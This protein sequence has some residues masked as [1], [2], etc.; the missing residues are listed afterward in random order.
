MTHKLL[1]RQLTTLFLWQIYCCVV[2]ASRNTFARGKRAGCHEIQKRANT[3]THATSR[4]WR[5]TRWLA[6]RTQR[7]QAVL[8]SYKHLQRIQTYSIKF[9]SD[10]HAFKENNQHMKKTSSPVLTSEPKYTSAPGNKSACRQGRG[11]KRTE[12]VK[13]VW[14]T[15]S[16]LCKT[17]GKKKKTWQKC[18]QLHANRA[19]PPHQS[20]PRVHL[21]GWFT[22]RGSGSWKPPRFEQTTKWASNQ[23]VSENTFTPGAQ[24]SSLVEILMDIIGWCQ[25]TVQLGSTDAE[26]Q[27]DGESGLR[28]GSLWLWSGE[29][30]LITKEEDGKTEEESVWYHKR[31][32]RHRWHGYWTWKNPPDFIGEKSWILLYLCFPWGINDKKRLNFSS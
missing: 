32:H 8:S 13:N 31:W 26:R 11:N 1:M 4:T 22:A 3:W 2:E 17:W 16:N 20:G 25:A 12:A 21:W 15:S 10:A 18:L 7:T 9:P 28:T 19:P 30:E 6:R 5:W 14:H 23:A 29:A 24:L 27:A